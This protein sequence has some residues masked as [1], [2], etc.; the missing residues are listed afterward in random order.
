MRLSICIPTVKGREEIFSGLYVFL[1]AQITR[2]N[3]EKEVEII[4][5]KD[6]KEISIGKKRD[7]LYRKSKG[8]FSVQID[9]DDWTDQNFVQKVYSVLN[10]DIDCVGYIEHCTINGKEQLSKISVSC[11]NWYELKTPIDGFTYF[12]TP[13]F[14]S[15]IKTEICRKVGVADM[16]FGED[17]HFSKRI[18]P[19]LSKE[20]FIN[21]KMYFYSA[22]SLTRD[23]HNLRYGIIQPKR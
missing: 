9:D 5:E 20:V 15:P 8:L 21:E 14:K 3:L 23:Q 19:L 6:N 22:N 18:F 10:K 1:S 2:L 12:R 17:H 11:K 4:T 16:R 7:I 13:F